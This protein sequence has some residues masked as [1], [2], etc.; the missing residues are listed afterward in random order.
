MDSPQEEV[1]GGTWKHMALAVPWDHLYTKSKTSLRRPSHQLPCSVYFTNV[2]CLPDSENIKPKSEF[3]P[4]NI[5]RKTDTRKGA[6]TQSLL[7]GLSLG[8]SFPRSRSTG[9][10]GPD[11]APTQ[12][13]V[14]FFSPGLQLPRLSPCSDLLVKT[15]VI[16]SIGL[17]VL[18]HF[19]L[20][21]QRDILL[22]FLYLMYPTVARATFYPRHTGLALG[23]DP[24]QPHIAALWLVVQA[25]DH[26]LTGLIGPSPN[27][28]REL[29]MS[30]GIDTDTIVN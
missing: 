4:Q 17:L 9:T 20:G 13:H 19:C 11:R 29:S 28:A 15:R 16:H 3:C 30:L 27:K 26:S 21:C 7:S 14:T 8:D 1:D 25:S 2:S 10:Q 5:P 23:K 22:S 6:W 18:E 24:L 12:L